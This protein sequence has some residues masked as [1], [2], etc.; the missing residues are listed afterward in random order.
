[1]AG[2]SYDAPVEATGCDVVTRVETPAVATSPR[3]LLSVANVIDDAEP[4]RWGVTG[5]LYDSYFTYDPS[6]EA[7]HGV[8]AM[9][10]DDPCP[11][12]TA[13]GS[14]PLTYSRAT[15]Y[16]AWSRIA[17]TGPQTDAMDYARTQYAVREERLLESI[18]DSIA[19]N[20]TPT[21]ST[22]LGI[23][24]D[25][26]LFETEF[27]KLYAGQ[28]TVWL[29]SFSANVAASLSLLLDGPGGT[30]MTASGNRV[31][32]LP[33]LDVTRPIVITPNLT[34]HR[35][36]LDVLDFFNRATNMQ[37]ALAQRQYLFVIDPDADMVVGSFT[38]PG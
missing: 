34:V 8:L 1:M 6:A 9:D 25:F 11:S 26:G 27:A 12:P 10:C 2:T 22:G 33:F 35:S 7:G 37:D 3:G 31:A 14:T 36:P 38:S 24:E 30:L 4:V 28:G 5:A 18:F 13:G 19:A 32:V 20:V 21:A 16:M 29:N 17:C 23:A 15:A